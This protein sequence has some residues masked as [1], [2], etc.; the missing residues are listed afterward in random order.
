[1][2]AHNI[3]YAIG[4]GALAGAGIIAIAA[5]TAAIMWKL[6]KRT[7]RKHRAGAET[8]VTKP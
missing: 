7:E 1:M 5:G 4:C 2:T 8:L 3:A 6:A